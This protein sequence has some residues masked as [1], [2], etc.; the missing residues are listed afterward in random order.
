VLAI[1]DLDPC[2]DIH[3]EDCGMYFQV[4]DLTKEET[5]PIPTLLWERNDFNIDKG[6]K[7]LN[8]KGYDVDY[9]KTKLEEDVPM[10]DICSM[11]SN[12]SETGDNDEKQMEKNQNS[13]LYYTSLSF[14]VY[15]IT[16]LNSEAYTWRHMPLL[17]SSYSENT[18][19]C[20]Y[21]I[22]NIDNVDAF[23][24]VDESLG[25][26]NVDVNI[27]ESVG[28]PNVDVNIDESVGAPNLD[29]NINESVDDTNVDV[30]M[31]N[32]LDEQQL[33]INDLI[34][35]LQTQEK[36]ILNLQD[37][38]EKLDEDTRYLGR[39]LSNANKKIVENKHLAEE[40]G[41]KGDN[42]SEEIRGL[43]RKIELLKDQ[44]KGMD[45]NRMALEKENERV[46]ELVCTLGNKIDE[47]ED[48][49]GQLQK[50]DDARPDEERSKSHIYFFYT[51]VCV[52]VCVSALRR[53]KPRE[54]PCIFFCFCIEKDRHHIFFSVRTVYN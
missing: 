51:V 9:L 15:R 26:P 33:K 38:N 53:E 50:D 48:T 44:I 10:P 39:L 20:K 22:K 8:E 30:N 25:A 23:Q 16:L 14:S 12:E 17:Y 13:I 2:V 49:I 28:A 36:S 21:I 47:L 24:N 46:Q 11:I 42:G 43:H 34:R 1:E 5:Y 27:D 3:D 18:H 4:A 19:T 54:A 7:W 52:C 41:N 40:N 37:R 32:T 35:K 45:A 31:D 6:K 29:V